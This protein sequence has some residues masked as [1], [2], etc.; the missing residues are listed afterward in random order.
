MQ[1][2][3][4]TMLYSKY[5]FNRKMVWQSKYSTQKTQYKPDTLMD[6]WKIDKL[7]SSESFLNFRHTVLLLGV[8]ETAGIA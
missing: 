4:Q 2:N 3:K 8:R 1:T 6:T 7:Y 5:I